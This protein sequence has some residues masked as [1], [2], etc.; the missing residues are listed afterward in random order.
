[1]VDSPDFELYDGRFD[2][3]QP[4]AFIDFHVPVEAR[5][6]G[7]RRMSGS[8]QKRASEYVLFLAAKKQKS[9][10]LFHTSTIIE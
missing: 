5:I 8:G 9:F 1:M 4:G 6:E 3:Q 7:K 10:I 2:P